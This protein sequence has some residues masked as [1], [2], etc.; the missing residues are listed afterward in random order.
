MPDPKDP[1]GN[2][3]TQLDTGTPGFEIPERGDGVSY[4]YD[5]GDPNRDPG[6][7]FPTS[8]GNVSVDDTKKDISK[9]TR[10]VL[11][12]YLGK[13]TKVNYYPVDGDV[14]P[15]FSTTKIFDDQNNVTPAIGGIT[16]SQH[17]AP[18]NVQEGVN[19]TYNGNTNSSPNLKSWMNSPLA[20]DKIEY[21]PPDAS[22][23]KLTKGKSKLRTEDHKN[24]NELLQQVKKNDLGTIDA[25]TTRVLTNNRFTGLSGTPGK[26]RFAPFMGPVTDKNINTENLED[27][28][29]AR[30]KFNPQV[31]NPIYPNFN[32]GKMAQV[33]I[34]LSTRASLELG[35]NNRDFN[36]SDEPTEVKAIVPS[37]NQLGISSVDTTTL[38]AADVLRNL[39]YDNEVPEQNYLNISSTSWGALNNVYDQYD[40]IAAAGMFTLSM[41]LIAAMI[42]LFE[43]ISLLFFG[44]SSSYRADQGRYYSGR[45]TVPKSDNNI[46]SLLPRALG[47]E[48][49]T[50]KPY[51]ECVRAGINAYFGIDTSGGLLGAVTSA[52][53]SAAKD[54]YASPGYK[55]AISRSVIRS[56]VNIINAIKNIKG[57]NLISSVKNFFSL[58]DTIRKSKLISTLKVFSKLGDQ[59]LTDNG[60]YDLP[61]EWQSEPIRKSFVDTIGDDAPGSTMSKQRLQKGRSLKLA[62]ASNRA[63]ALY[64]LPNSVAA[65]QPAMRDLGSFQNGYEP[66]D[67]ARNKLSKTRFKMTSEN[68]IPYD[69]EEKSVQHMENLIEGTDHIPLYFHD[70]RTNEII[71]FHAFVE[72]LSDSYTAQYDS[73][74]AFGRIE[75]VRIYQNTSRKVDITFYVVSTSRQD[76]DEMWLKINKLV[77]LVYPQYTEGRRITDVTGQYKFTQPF[78]QLVGASPLIRIRMGNIFTSNYSRFAVARLFGATLNGTQFGEGGTFDFKGVETRYKNAKEA[79]EKAWDTQD[80][81]YVWIVKSGGTMN[82]SDSTIALPGIPNIFKEDLAP[83]W[84]LESDSMFIP[85]KLKKSTSNNNIFAT[86]GIPDSDFLTN[87][88]ITDTFVQN[89]IISEI[90][91]KYDNPN[92]PAKRIIEGNYLVSREMVKL[93]GITE[94]KIYAE[95]AGSNGNTAL[96]N[97]TEFLDTE[98][99]AVI[100]SFKSTAG[101]GLA[102]FIDS[103]SFDWGG[104][105]AR[106]ELDHDAR[107]PQR[108]KVTIS[109]QP[110]H[111][112][113]PGIDSQGYNRAPVYPVGHFAHGND[114]LKPK[115][116]LKWHLADTIRRPSL[117]MENNMAPQLQFPQ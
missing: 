20:N 15:N 4:T 83:T 13:K 106:W 21:N 67:V 25:Y 33:G 30:N 54:S 14:D 85:V 44:G 28:E 88:G 74:Q 24:G 2:S 115:G 39:S 53:F 81:S 76:F 29:T 64:I 61:G 22:F 102:G 73:P 17:Y 58:I 68:R 5:V 31:Y 56:I 26:D 95:I 48:F 60:A 16:N 38:T 66:D 55:V 52:F 71:S 93:A 8:K 6:V 117:T 27:L 75:P 107:V 80:P 19:P 12:D 79:I 40:G 101:K 57:A 92:A 116:E 9:Y 109:F 90:I 104:A 111:D 72:S 63:S 18:P 105:D 108:C 103:L 36:P 99:N 34:A 65:L 51:G 3:T 47:I 94:K 45:S 87:Q 43:G 37:P 113:T 86:P 11:A 96:T 59:V 98:K 91:N 62:W 10:K 77:T 89:K 84:T 78:S 7:S 112:I 69:G 42:L 49:N 1:A 46:L 82:K 50:V 100:K 23:A 41:A 32:M 70:L 110:I 97:L 35:T 114:T